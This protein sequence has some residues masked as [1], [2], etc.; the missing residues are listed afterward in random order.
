VT[1]KVFEDNTFVTQ[2]VAAAS[3]RRV[4]VVDAG[5]SL[6]CSM[7][8]D[9]VAQAACDN[10]WAGLLIFGAIRDSQAIA[11]SISACRH[12]ARSRCAASRR[13]SDSAIYLRFAGVA[14]VPGHH[15]Y[16]DDDGVILA[17]RNILS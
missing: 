11:V 12:S 2:T 8:G 1:L 4:L 16:C 3:D 17:P 9:N 14:P 7:V 15:V 10:G 13:A 6:R 5:G